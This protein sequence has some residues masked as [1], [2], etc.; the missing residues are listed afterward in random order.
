MTLGGLGRQ[1]PRPLRDKMAVTAVTGKRGIRS[2]SEL[3]H[4]GVINHA[5]KAA[6]CAVAH[7]TSLQMCDRSSF[8]C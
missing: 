1:G 6:G 5:C 4:G 8:T 3:Q 2:A 7:L